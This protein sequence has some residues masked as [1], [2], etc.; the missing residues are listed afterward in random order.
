LKQTTTLVWE[1]WKQ[2]APLI[3]NYIFSMQ[4][5][6]EPFLNLKTISPSREIS[7]EKIQASIVKAL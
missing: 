3:K 2:R 5:I 4:L 1:I 7:D 6:N